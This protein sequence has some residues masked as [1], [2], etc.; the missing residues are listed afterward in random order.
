MWLW[1][2]FGLNVPIGSLSFFVYMKIAFSKK[3]KKKLYENRVYIQEITNQIK[4]GFNGP[5]LSLPFGS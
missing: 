1:T 5:I 2:F 4:L 3:K